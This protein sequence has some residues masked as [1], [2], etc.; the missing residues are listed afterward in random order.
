M[1]G[2]IVLIAHSQLF[3]ELCLVV[4][5][6]V[7]W[8][9]ENKLFTLGKRLFRCLVEMTQFF[10]FS[11]NTVLSILSFKIDTDHFHMAEIIFFFFSFSVTVVCLLLDFDFISLPHR[12]GQLDCNGLLTC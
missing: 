4:L 2:S 6:A 5:E 9:F 10:M 7:G 12:C 1:I 8:V 3:Q 11:V